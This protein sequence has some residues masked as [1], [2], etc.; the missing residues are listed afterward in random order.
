MIRQFQKNAVQMLPRKRR[1]SQILYRP[2]APYNTNAD[3]ID[4]HF[5]SAQNAELSLI[6]TLIED[7]DQD[8]DVDYC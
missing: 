8:D 5:S 7:Y 2:G 6:R 4:A 3:I 1:N